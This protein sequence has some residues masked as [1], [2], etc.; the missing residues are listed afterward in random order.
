LVTVEL[1]LDRA[2]GRGARLH[3][4]SKNPVDVLDIH[5]HRH[6]RP[7]DGLRAADASVRIL[8]R[9]HDH[10]IAELELGMADLAV[11]L[12]H[13]HPLGRPEHRP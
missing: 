13:A 9:E 3:G 5:T 4:S 7:T 8:V 11:G 6:R 1:V 2:Q 10:A 12:G